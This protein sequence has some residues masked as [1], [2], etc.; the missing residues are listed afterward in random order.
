MARKVTY[1]TT[2]TFDAFRLKLNQKADYV[3]DLD[4]LNRAIITGDKP[5]Y[6]RS[7]LDSS[8]DGHAHQQS[9]SSLSLINTIN[10]IESGYR[11]IY[12][13]IN[14]GTGVL[15]VNL[16]GVDSA[17]FNIVRTGN[18]ITDSDFLILDSA[19]F[20]RASGTTL[21][22]DSAEID[23]ARINFLSGSY[24]K[25]DSGWGKGANGSIIGRTAPYWPGQGDFNILRFDSLAADSAIYTNI[26]G[27]SAVYP[28]GRV[29]GLLIDSMA[30]ADSSVSDTMIVT[31]LNTNILKFDNR[32]LDE[33]TVLRVTNESGT[34]Q[35]AGYLTS[36]DNDSAIA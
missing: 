25:Y 33:F 7:G 29:A 9:P 18:I 31:D 2:D 30:L 6:S 34:I 28:I 15:K 8:L 3:G 20:I 10:L 36:E 1:T 5:Y 12:N 23:S 11:S 13:S 14:D 27:D 21:D 24:L 32:S 26:S 19:S 4:S 22:F 16:L 17:V 35:L